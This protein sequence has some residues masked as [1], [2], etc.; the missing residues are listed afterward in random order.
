[1]TNMIDVFV[2]VVG[3]GREGEGLDWLCS[4]YV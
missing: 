4:Y 2:M 3:G 1:M